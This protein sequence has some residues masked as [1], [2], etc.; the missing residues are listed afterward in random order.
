V[1]LSVS[2]F[3]NNNSSRFG[4]FLTLQFSATGRM[5]GASMKTYL[6]E[7]SRLTSQLPGEHNYHVLYTVAKG[8]SAHSRKEWGL[9]ASSNVE[10]FK[11]L[12]VKKGDVEWD[13]FPC[14][15]PELSGA[16]H[17]IPHLDSVQDSCWKVVMAI[18]YLGNVEFLGKVEDD[19]VVSDKSVLA[20]VAK[21]LSCEPEQLE[22]AICTQN[23]K[24]GLDWISKPNTCEYAVNVKHALT[25][26]RNPT[27]GCPAQRC[28]G[29]SARPCAGRV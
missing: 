7:K 18:L 19:A 5:L 20:K 24:A 9:P 3:R 13:Q 25:K 1:T 15:F 29:R 6:L 22:K 17:V 12:N 8:L 10:D 23:I 14:N 28:S 2:R 4:K 21:L 26:V 16:M 27:C 11:L